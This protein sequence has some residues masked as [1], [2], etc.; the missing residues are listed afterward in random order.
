M[1]TRPPVPKGGIAV[2]FRTQ[3]WLW[4]HSLCYLTIKGYHTISGTSCSKRMKNDKDQV[5]VFSHRWHQG[6][7]TIVLHTWA[8]TNTK[9]LWTGDSGKVM[10]TFPTERWAPSDPTRQ[11]CSNLLDHPRI[12]L[13]PV[14]LWTEDGDSTW[15]R[16]TVQGAHPSQMTVAGGMV[17][18]RLCL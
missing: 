3:C 17:K 4:L 15:I 7:Q 2:S 14:S 11:L 18:P 13:E 8:Q 9:T 1:Q 5:M 10:R 16:S 12:I 6:T